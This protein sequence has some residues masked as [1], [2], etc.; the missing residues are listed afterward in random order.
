MFFTWKYIK[1][2]Y[3]FYFLKLILI[4]IHQNDLKT[5]KNNLKQKNLNF[6]KK[7]SLILISNT[8]K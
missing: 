5:L 4:S 3:I 2:I 8:L 7:T 6:N 1:I